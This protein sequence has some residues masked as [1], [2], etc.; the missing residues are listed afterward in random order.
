MR[1]ICETVQ[2]NHFQSLELVCGKVVLPS[3]LDVFFES[4]WED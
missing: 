1:E 2:Q 3:L 4:L